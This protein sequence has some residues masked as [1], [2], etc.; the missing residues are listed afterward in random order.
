MWLTE[1]ESYPSPKMPSNRPKAK[2]KPGSVCWTIR[3]KIK[4]THIA[5][6]L[7]RSCLSEALM[8]DF[9]ITN[10]HVVLGDKATQ[11]SRAVANLERSTVLLIGRRA[12]RIVLAV[13][14][15]SDRTAL[16]RGNPN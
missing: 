15:A 1:I 4:G 12:F 13:Q 3:Y 11:A 10:F 6:K 7:T 2:A 9:K 16:G 8:L 5:L 14:V